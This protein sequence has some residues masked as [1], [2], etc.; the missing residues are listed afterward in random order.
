MIFLGG[1]RSV[2]HVVPVKMLGKDAVIS[3][4]AWAWKFSF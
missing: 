4:P 3:M 2:S 1:S